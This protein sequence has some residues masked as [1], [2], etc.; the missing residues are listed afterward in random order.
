V[1]IGKYNQAVRIENLD[2]LFS[3]HIYFWGKLKIMGCMANPQFLCRH[4]IVDWQKQY[5]KSGFVGFT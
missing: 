4:I 2:F 3:R 1:D 5:N